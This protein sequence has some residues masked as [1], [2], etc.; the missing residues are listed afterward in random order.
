MDCR[1]LS[2]LLEELGV[3]EAHE[4]RY[5]SK[6]RTSGRCAICSNQCQ[7]EYSAIY[8]AASSEYF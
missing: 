7:Q 4:L 1:G 5:L 8:G 6:R 3:T 2:A